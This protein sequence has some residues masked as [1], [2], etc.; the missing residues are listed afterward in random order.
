MP[1]PSD[2]Q[3]SNVGL[4]SIPLCED[5]WR[6]CYRLIA[7]RF[8]TV[9]LFD[10]IADPADLEVVFAIESLTNPRLRQA[11]GELSLVRP[12]ERVSGPGS[13]PI[14]A[15]FTHLNPEGSRFSRGDF[16]V[17]YAADRLQTAVAEVSHHRARF[18]LRTREGAIDLDLRL[19][20]ADVLEPLHD[21]REWA[22][23]HLSAVEDPDDYAAAQALGRRLRDAG[24]WGACY[25]SVRDPGGHCLAVWRPRALGPARSDRHIGLH[26]DGQRITHWYVKELPQPLRP[27]TEVFSL[28]ED[29]EDY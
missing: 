17:Y 29:R 14:M 8:P 6:P 26:W 3:P 25:R 7:S 18:L 9:G 20:L 5:R 13:T 16:G 24:S 11:L 23:P 12:A 28:P 19:V 21:L 2:P 10:E 1:P 22:A 27:A 4:G 15:A